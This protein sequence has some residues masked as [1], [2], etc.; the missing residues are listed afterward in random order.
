MIPR[1]LRCREGLLPY[2]F[3]FFALEYGSTD[4]QFG[5]WF[6]Y[7][8]RLERFEI[9]SEVFTEKLSSV[10]HMDLFIGTPALVE[11]LCG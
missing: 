9:E 10:F 7:A 1:L 6:P 3:P 11:V 2:P 5:R 8:S 4:E